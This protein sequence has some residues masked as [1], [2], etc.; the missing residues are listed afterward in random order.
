MKSKVL[1]IFAVLIFSAGMSYGQFKMPEKGKSNVNRSTSNLILGIFNPKNFTMTQSFQ[2]SMLSGGYG[3]I[4][5]TSY[6]NSMNYKVSDRLSIGADVKLSYSPFASS[7][8]GKEYDTQL[9]NDMSGLSLSKLSVDYKISDNSYISFQYRK[10]D[11]YY[12]SYNPFY[13][14]NG[15]NSFNRR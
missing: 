1:L 14:D 6:V 2:M 12:D 3:N 13:R 11:G 8:Y 5:L 7:G 10:Y 9:Q 4:A 15:F